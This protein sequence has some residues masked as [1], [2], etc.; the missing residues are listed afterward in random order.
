VLAIQV[1][2]LSGTERSVS[3]D[4]LLPEALEVTEP[5]TAIALRARRR[6]R[7]ILRNAHLP[8]PRDAPA[9]VHDARQETDPVRQPGAAGSE[10]DR[11]VVDPL[12]DRTALFDRPTWKLRRGSARE[13]E[14]TTVCRSTPSRVARPESSAMFS[15]TSWGAP[16]STYL[17]RFWSREPGATDLAKPAPPTESIRSMQDH[18]EGGANAGHR[19]WRPD[20]TIRL[21]FV[22]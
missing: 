12:F 17:R 21:R 6:A 1:K 10:L 3:L 19:Q 7:K 15:N 18:T 11:E 5:P 4:V 13:G 14:V 2:D 16:L 9:E 20:L 8:R 22:R